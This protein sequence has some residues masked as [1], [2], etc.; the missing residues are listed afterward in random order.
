MEVTSLT[1]VADEQLALARRSRSGRAALTI[2]GGHDHTL[3]QTVL[4]LLAGHHL[5]EHDSPGEATLHV[6]HG[7]VRL[8]TSTE[9]WEATRGDHLTI[10]PERH[11]LAALEDAAVLLTVATPPGPTHG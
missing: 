11:A 7:H 8:T 4:A 1:A 2:H 9:A 5:A 6:L 3:R 10:P